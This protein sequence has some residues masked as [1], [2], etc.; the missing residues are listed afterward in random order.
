MS[1]EIT[2][3][4]N[5][6]KEQPQAQPDKTI[7]ALGWV[8][9]LISIY[10]ILRQVLFIIGETLLVSYTPEKIGSLDIIY[11]LVS[12]G[13]AIW[14]FILGNKIRK[15][16]AKNPSDI[17]K[18]FILSLALT[19]LKIVVE[20]FMFDDTLPFLWILLVPFLIKGFLDLRS[21][22]PKEK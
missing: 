2:N 4:N 3:S 1:K 8:V 22:M 21:V 17:N 19:V 11:F 9:F 5:L 7:K 14:M 20:I 16:G 10:E 12:L 13:I 15:V 6:G 18:A